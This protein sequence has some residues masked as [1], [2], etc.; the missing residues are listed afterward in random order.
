[1]SVRVAVVGVTLVIAFAAA[2]LARL[3]RRTTKTAAGQ[4]SRKTD[5]A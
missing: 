3:F 1:M 2:C 4:P 5:P